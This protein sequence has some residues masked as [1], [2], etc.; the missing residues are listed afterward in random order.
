MRPDARQPSD[1]L[2]GFHRRLR[3][4]QATGNRDT[5]TRRPGLRY[6]GSYH[7]YLRTDERRYCIWHEYVVDASW[8]VIAIS[9][10]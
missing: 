3:S 7:D 10:R 1:M 2:E 5:H 4:N 6:A 8:H 9:R